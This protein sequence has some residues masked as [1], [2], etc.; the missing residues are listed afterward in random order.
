MQSLVWCS[1]QHLASLQ[2]AQSSE[3]FSIPCMSS[4]PL[5]AFEL[6]EGHEGGRTDERRKKQYYWSLSVQLEVWLMKAFKMNVKK[7]D[8]PW[9]FVAV[10]A[11]AVVYNARILLRSGQSRRDGRSR[12]VWRARYTCMYLTRDPIRT[13]ACCKISDAQVRHWCV[14]PLHRERSASLEREETLDPEV[15]LWVLLN[16]H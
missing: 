1:L 3:T 10:R 8:A 12:A 15:W 14:W 16:Q 5:L 2:F 4:F 9:K 6:L 11:S 7:Q 13:N